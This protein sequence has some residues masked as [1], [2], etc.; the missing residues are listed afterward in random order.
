M[1]ER[2]GAEDLPWHE[3]EDDSVMQDAI[4]RLLTDT[5]CY[6]CSALVPADR[7][8]HRDGHAWCFAHRPVWSHS[9]AA[10]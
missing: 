6:I 8:W 2:I 1:S 3:P 4:H 9:E 10:E 5:P 7:G